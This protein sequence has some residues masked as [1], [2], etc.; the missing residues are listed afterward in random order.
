M[1]EHRTTPVGRRY[2]VYQIVGIVLAV[3]F[4]ALGVAAYLAGG[5][6]VIAAIAV[7]GG[8]AVLI[9]SIITMVRS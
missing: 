4:L 1:S 2:R 5:G 9:V 6:P 3:L 7:I 8:L